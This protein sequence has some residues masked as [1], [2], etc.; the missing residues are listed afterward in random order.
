MANL[1][2]RLLEPEWLDVLPPDDVAARNSRR[3]LQKLNFLM[4]HRRSLVRLL[5][6]ARIEERA[7]CL[8]DLGS[9]DGCFALGVIGSLRM[10]TPS[11]RLVLVDRQLSLTGEVR[12]KIE[13]LAWQLEEARAD[14][15]AFVRQ[16]SPSS[17]FAIANLFLHHFEPPQLRALFESL[18]TKVDA[19]AACEPRR[20]R[21]A[22]AATSFLPLIGCNGVTRHDADVSVRAGF[23][24][25]ELSELWPAAGDWH[26]RE[27]ACGLFSHSFLAW[28]K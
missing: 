18:A 6:I 14:V 25:R 15:F 22:L 28:K 9:G 5:R 19:F 7:Q 2:A 3:D 16:L 13:A 24:A 17:T 11:P 21:T 26:L 27:A 12:R 4:G 10:Q 8:V 1:Q 23:R 20:S